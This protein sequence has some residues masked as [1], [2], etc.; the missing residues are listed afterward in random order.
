MS[1]GKPDFMATLREAADQVAKEEQELV[2]AE[3]NN[4]V[5]EIS[6]TSNPV[7]LSNNN[8]M[9]TTKGNSEVQ[10]S[11]SSLKRNSDAEMTYVLCR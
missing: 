6:A 10:L 1:A 8:N 3:L 2:Q 4:A 7:P 9:E 5:N 11:E